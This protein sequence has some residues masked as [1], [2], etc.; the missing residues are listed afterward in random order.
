MRPLVEYQQLWP[1]HAE[2]IAREY[3]SLVGSSSEGPDRHEVPHR[4]ASYEVIEEIGRGAQGVVY[5][6]HDTRL[7]RVVALKVLRSHWTHDARTMARFRRE[8]LAASRLDHP[9]ICTVYD[10][11]IE[12]G[13]AYI[14][15][16]WVEGE[17]LAARIARR[18]A[19]G[20]RPPSGGELLATVEQVE[21]VA[22]ALHAA[23][24]RGI[25][26]RDLKPGNVMIRPDG[27]AVVLDFGLAGGREAGL[28]T[29]TASGEIFGTPA[30]MAPETLRGEAD[31][32][33]IAADVYALGVVLYEALTLRLPFEATSLDSLYR[34]ILDGT[35]RDPREESAAVTLDLAVIVRTAMDVAASRRYQTAEAFAEDLRRFR[36]R[37][38]VLARPAPWWL[39]LRRW[40]ERNPAL[41]TLTVGSFVVLSTALAVTGWL[42][43]ESEKQRAVVEA[44]LADAKVGRRSLLERKVEGLLQRGF[45]VAFGV[46]A[47]PA[48][49]IFDQ[50]LALDPGNA[51][52]L[53][54]RFL[55]ELPDGERAVAVLDAAGD[56]ADPDVWFMRAMVHGLAGRESE[57]QRA[58][59]KAGAEGSDLRA[60]LEG[61]RAVRWFTPPVDP[62]AAHEA[63]SRFR[64]AAMRA[65]RPR[66]HHYHS[67][68]MAAQAAGD[69]PAM[70]EAEAALRHHWPDAQATW[71]A[72]AQ[73]YFPVDAEKA[74][75]A[76]HRILALG[77][78]APAHLGLAHWRQGRGEMDDALRELDLA[79]ETDPDLPHARWLRGRAL[80]AAGRPADAVVDLLRIIERAD[81]QPY[82]A[83]D[84]AAALRAAA[85]PDLTARTLRAVERR[86]PDAATLVR[87]AMDDVPATSP[88]R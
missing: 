40:S 3:A 33:G 38:P 12:D 30:Y 18:K 43:D 44:A 14:A 2:L 67:W 59:E 8:A 65:P 77:P 49:G 75:D 74:V 71:E 25:V 13:W 10:S 4:I 68:M 29:L 15:M 47:A 63:L 35:A 76:L 19:D 27:A 82:V 26:H 78:S 7:D 39:R 60:F 88:M 61:H 42:L 28:P 50:A 1:G 80:V 51:T 48:R 69:R 53:A 32:N 6:A 86:A 62:A 79:V 70:D 81:L 24:E 85:D 36:T 72:I 9:G 87:D 11:G 31:R 23:H 41:S 83:P 52:A 57:R 5:R 84:L 54:G 55:A 22:R 21:H 20:T 58:L 45:Q 16:R 17:T 34:A 37:E 64:T 66:F 73:F 46:D 56:D